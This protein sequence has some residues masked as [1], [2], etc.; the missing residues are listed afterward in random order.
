MIIIKEETLYLSINFVSPLNLDNTN[1]LG[2][3]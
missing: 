3:R 2:L 1:Y